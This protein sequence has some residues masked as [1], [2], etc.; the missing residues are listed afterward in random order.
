MRQYLLLLLFSFCLLLVLFHNRINDLKT[1]YNIPVVI[2]FSEIILIMVQS[3]AFCAA[4]SAI[5]FISFRKHSSEVF[6][7]ECFCHFFFVIR[8]YVFLY[9]LLNHRIKRKFFSHDIQNRTDIIVIGK[10]HNSRCP[11]VQICNKYVFE[12][13]GQRVYDRKLFCQRFILLLPLAG[14]LFQHLYRKDHMAQITIGIQIFLY[15]VQL[16]KSRN[17]T[18]KINE[19]ML[20]PPH[21]FLD[22]IQIQEV[23]RGSQ[24][25]FIRQRCHNRFQIFIIFVAV[26]YG[27][28]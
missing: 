7:L 1:S 14:D 20:L 11:A 21:S 24:A 10:P 27:M 2:R 3:P 23:Q 26:R 8:I 16:A 13:F 18:V 4:I 25:L 17:L 19:Y 22:G 15:K 5:V 12:I 28:L 9:P 6:Q